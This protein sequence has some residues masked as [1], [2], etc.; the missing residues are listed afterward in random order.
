VVIGE[1]TFGKGSV[2]AILPVVDNEAMRLTIARY[3]L[4][5]GRTI[6]AEGVVPDIIVYPGDVPTKTSEQGIKEKDLKKHLEG[7]LKKT[8]DAN[9][10][11]SEKGKDKTKMKDKEPLKEDKTIVSQENLFKDMQLKSAVDAIKILSIKK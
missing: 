1:K 6:Q 5:S 7:E 8:D 2:Q 3:Y 10:T 11:T 9:I 4:P